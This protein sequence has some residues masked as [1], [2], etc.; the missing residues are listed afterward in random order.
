MTLNYD[1]LFERHLLD[2]AE[3][4][5]LTLIKMMLEKEVESL[6][7]MVTDRNASINRLSETI[8]RMCGEK[9]KEKVIADQLLAS[10]VTT[11]GDKSIII[12]DLNQRLMKYKEK[13]ESLAVDVVEK[14]QELRE[15][16]RV[17]S[18]RY[19]TIMRQ[20]GKLLKL[21]QQRA[22]IYEASKEWVAMYGTASIMPKQTQELLNKLKEIFTYDRYCINEET[23]E[24]VSSCEKRTCYDDS[25]GQTPPGYGSTE[26][27]RKTPGS[28]KQSYDYRK[29][30]L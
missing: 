30:G 2:K 15:K 6:T 7:K 27:T 5:E 4:R 9:P 11:V 14:E 18:D 22:E 16:E 24:W 20:A 3:N 19:D 12:N 26:P 29:V 1:E 28:P 17:L 13:V 10:L 23:N 21:Q 8:S 25:Q